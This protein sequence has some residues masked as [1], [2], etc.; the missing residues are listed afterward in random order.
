MAM[1]SK[2]A[3]DLLPEL[4]SKGLL[5]RLSPPRNPVDVVV[6]KGKNPQV[7]LPTGEEVEGERVKAL[8][9]SRA[10]MWFSARNKI[11]VEL[12]VSSD[13]IARQPLLI[14]K[15]VLA[16][17]PLQIFLTF[18]FLRQWHFSPAKVA[19]QPTAAVYVV[20]LNANLGP[21]G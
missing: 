2:T 4:R 10:P 17:N 11:I 20:V 5:T 3:L 18:A 12:I 21:G 16:A 6:K 8:A 15:V 13:G 9:P 7:L 14:S 1:D 19:S